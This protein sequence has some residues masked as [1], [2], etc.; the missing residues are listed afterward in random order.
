M[1]I[2]LLLQEMLDQ[3]ASDIHLKVGSP[4]L[5][6][7]DGNLVNFGDDKLNTEQ[8]E[9]I[10]NSLM[11]DEQKKKF[12]EVKQIDAAYDINE[13]RLRGNLCHQK[14]TIAI[15]LRVIPQ[16]INT[17]EELHLPQILK[18][19][20]LESR[21][22]I[23]VTGTAGSGKSTTMAAMINYININQNKNI[24]TIEDPIEYVH[25]DAKSCVSQREVR[26]DVDSFADALTNVLRQD[27]DVVMVG[28]M[29]DYETIRAAVNAA[30][31]GHMVISSLHTIEASQTVDRIIDTFPA[32]QHSQIRGQM[33]SILTAVI[34]LRLIPMASGTGRVPAVEVLRAT[35]TIRSLIREQKTSQLRQ[36]IQ[37]GG[38]QYGMQTFDQSLLELY[39]IGLISMESALAEATS[40]TDLKM[41]MDGIVTGGITPGGVGISSTGFTKKKQG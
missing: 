6:R 39:K 20:S 4:P 32:E 41:S 18:T 23:L 29:R 17:F 40:P 38:N 30:E 31:T 26:V 3:Q 35:P 24:V 11:T 2:K 14:G 9:A 12:K 5:W 25:N 13:W 22:L 7:I 15:A 34:S 10:A 28:E 19:I 1:N 33:A 16:K 37:S 27:P 8:I 21:G 36:A